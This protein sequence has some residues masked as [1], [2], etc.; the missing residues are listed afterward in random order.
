M[1]HMPF[2][3]STCVTVF[4]LNSS[5]IKVTEGSCCSLEVARIEKKIFC[6]RTHFDPAG[7][8]CLS[9]LVIERNTGKGANGPAI[10]QFFCKSWKF[11]WFLQIRNLFYRDSAL[12]EIS[13]CHWI[14]LVAVVLK[15]SQ[16]AYT[17]ASPPFNLFLKI[18]SFTFHSSSIFVILSFQ[19]YL[20]SLPPCSSSRWPE[21]PSGAF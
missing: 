16:S 11:L 10:I 8:A 3:P 21:C 17:P 15:A 14:G 7:R 18:I 20:S 4:F 6:S 12:L 5:I 19:A 1:L 2:E 13:D 9:S